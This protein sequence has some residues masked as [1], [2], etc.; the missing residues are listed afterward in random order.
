MSA[1]AQITI[2]G[3]LGKD[4]VAALVEVAMAAGAALLVQPR[5]IATTPVVEV[6]PAR[7]ALPS[8]RRVKRPAKA[9]AA[10]TAALDERVRRALQK[11]PISTKEFRAATG[12]SAYRTQ[13]LV[14]TGAL[15]ATGV[16]QSRRLSLPG[17][18]KEEP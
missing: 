9:A 2:C 3:V 4:T 7:K 15:V 1:P 12:L 14:A 16:T 8:A 13:Q 17:S 5:A 6:A 10:P 11:G 18:A